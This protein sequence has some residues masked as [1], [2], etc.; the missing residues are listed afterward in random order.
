[1]NKKQSIIKAIKHLNNKK[2]FI[3][4]LSVKKILNKQKNNSKNTSKRHI[5][6]IL[7][8]LINDKILIYSAFSREKTA[9]NYPVKKYLLDLHKLN[10]KK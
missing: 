2:S 5:Y 8:E 4:Y 1:M 10:N 6:R 3:Y 7:N 9:N